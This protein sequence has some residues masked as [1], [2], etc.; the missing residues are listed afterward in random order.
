[1]QPFCPFLDMKQ[2]VICTMKN[3]FFKCSMIL[4]QH[5]IIF[6]TLM[7]DKKHQHAG[8]KSVVILNLLLTFTLSHAKRKCEGSTFVFI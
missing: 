8:I 1:M 2:G 6:Q 3:T 7:V 4:F 5:K